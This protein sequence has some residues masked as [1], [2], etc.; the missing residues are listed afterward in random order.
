M[1][2]ECV[3]NLNYREYHRISDEL[4][5]KVL[6]YYEFLKSPEAPEV[7]CEIPPLL[8]VAEIAKRE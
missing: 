5:Q 3:T 1:D 7:D 2:F 8:V 6:E 4:A